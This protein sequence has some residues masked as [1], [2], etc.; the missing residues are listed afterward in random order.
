MKKKTIEGP[1]GIQMTD[2]LAKSLDSLLK[3]LPKECREL[4][5][6]SSIPA[7]FDL[8]PGERADVSLVSVESIDREGDVVL[9]KGCDLTHFMGNPVVTMAHKYDELP[10]GK[11]AWIKH[12]PGG[13][14]AKTI[15]ASKP[16]GWDG[17]WLPDAVWSMTREGIL[18]GKSIG[19]L[20]TRIRP[21]AKEEPQ[22]KNATA[23]VETSILLEYAVAPIPVNQDALVQAVAKGLTDEAML[24]KL[25]LHVPTR[26]KSVQ[27]KTVVDEAQA[28]LKALEAIKIDPEKIVRQVLHNIATRGTV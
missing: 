24:R 28:V 21:P 10:V 2:K 22:F 12:V 17:P 13:I 7:S 23:V 4:R 27:K 16:E 18:K 20:P 3:T 19:F 5:R 25:G 11:A 1:F 6:K 14:T 26:K 9:A 15:Y 8:V